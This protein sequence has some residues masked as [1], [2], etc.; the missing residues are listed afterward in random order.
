VYEA[1]IEGRSTLLQLVQQ[2][3][4]SSCSIM[5]VSRRQLACQEWRSDTTSP[6][7]K[8]VSIKQA[9]LRSGE[10]ALRKAVSAL[11]G[12]ENRTS[13]SQGISSA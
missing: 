2:M 7:A 12:L 4:N 1:E 5:S 8:T 9:L 6:A 10:L 11:G 13:S 3:I